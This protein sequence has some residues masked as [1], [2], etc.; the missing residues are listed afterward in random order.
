MTYIERLTGYAKEKRE[1]DRMGL[2]SAEYE[3]AV[4]AL[5]KKWGI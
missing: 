5:A 1:I 3:A 4:K 2:S